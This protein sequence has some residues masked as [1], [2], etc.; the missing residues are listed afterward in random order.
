[1]RTWVE[2][3]E[4]MVRGICKGRDEMALKMIW[5]RDKVSQLR[6]LYPIKKFFSTT[7][8]QFLRPS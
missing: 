8:V 1:V 7:Y 4:E 3:R 2:G 5:L 6:T